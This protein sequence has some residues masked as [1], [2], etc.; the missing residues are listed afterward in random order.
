MQ[1][2]ENIKKPALDYP[3]HTIV[4]SRWSPR[5]YDIKSIETDKLQHIFEAVR[6]TASS[7]N[8]QPWYFLVG[9]NGDDVYQKLLSTLVEFN[10]MWAVNAPVLVL[11]IS[12]TLNPKGEANHSHSYDMG[13]AMATLSLQAISEGIYIHQMGGFDKRAAAEL[14]EIPE[15]YAVQVAFTMGYRSDDAVLHPNIEKLETS[16]RLRRPISESVFTGSFGH[17][18]DFL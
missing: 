2:I 9:F 11:A 18:A 17:R 10:Q 13:Q 1:N 3:V 6:W 14:L 12:A 7:N 15:G 5:A 16:P 4:A 8:L